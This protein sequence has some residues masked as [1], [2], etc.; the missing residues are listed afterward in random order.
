[1]NRPAPGEDA[2][3]QVVVGDDAEGAVGPPHDDAAAAH[4]RHPPDGVGHALLRGADG[5][6]PGQ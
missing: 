5:N 6:Q 1:M 2:A 3:A 4:L